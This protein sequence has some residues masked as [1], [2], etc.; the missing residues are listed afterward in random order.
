MWALILA[1]LYVLCAYISLAM[2][3]LIL[4]AVLH[5]LFFLFLIQIKKSIKLKFFEF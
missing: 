4:G 5:L 2:V 1:S 3:W